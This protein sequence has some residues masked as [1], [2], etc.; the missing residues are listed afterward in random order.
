MRSG[1]LARLAGVSPDTLR[2]YERAGLLP[3]PARSAGGYRLY[4]GSALQ[5]LGLIRGALALGFRVEELAEVF[6]E[7]DSGVAPCRR[8]RNLAQAKLRELDARIAMLRSLR[9]LLSATLG[10]WDQLLAKA[11]RGKRAGLLETFVAAHPEAAEAL[12]PQLS[13][14]LRRR[15]AQKEKRQ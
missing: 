4:P 3:P 13:P 8:V 11:G 1:A 12:S 9:K 6:R 2:F 5:R 10:D 14:G 15:L 7:R